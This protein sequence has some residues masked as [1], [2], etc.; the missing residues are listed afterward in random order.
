MYTDPN[1][2]DRVMYTTFID[3][4]EYVFT[5]KRLELAPEVEVISPT[6]EAANIEKR[7]KFPWIC[8]TPAQVDLCEEAI[9]QIKQRV[10]TRGLN[11]RLTFQEYDK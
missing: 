8:A 7:R 6:P 5:P 9:A 2:P 1:D 3:D 10:R 11:L 4:I